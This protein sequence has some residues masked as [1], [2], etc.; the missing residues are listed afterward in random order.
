[1][2]LQEKVSLVSPYATIWNPPISFYTA[3][4]MN[5]KQEKGKKHKASSHI[6]DVHDILWIYMRN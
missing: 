1:M 5:Q 2:Y 3:I 6:H 4:W